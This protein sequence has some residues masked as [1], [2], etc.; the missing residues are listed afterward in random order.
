MYT[1]RYCDRLFQVYGSNKN[2]YLQLDRTDPN[3]KEDIS[4][5][6]A[7]AMHKAIIGVCQLEE[8][9]KHSEHGFA[10]F[11]AAKA[12]SKYYIVYHLFTCCMLLDPDFQIRFYE[13]IEDFSYGVDPDRLTSESHSPDDWR[14][15]KQLEEDLAVGI[16]HGAIKSYCARLRRYRH[17]SAPQYVKILYSNFVDQNTAKVLFEKISYIRDRSIYRPTHVV[18]KDNGD[19]QTSKHVRNQIDGLPNSSELFEILRKMHLQIC[20]SVTWENGDLLTAYAM[21]FAQENV[22]CGTDYPLALGYTWELLEKM[23][24][25]EGEGSVPTFLCQLMELVSPK[26]A[27]CFYEKYWSKLIEQTNKILY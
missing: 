24:G 21:R 11:R 4:A 5:S 19:Y 1:K 13:S 2:C 10:E 8:L 3:N 17:K 7:L 6:A 14:L 23:G 9:E 15:R 26:A 18:T 25:D 22:I 16:T 27:I 20:R 12:I